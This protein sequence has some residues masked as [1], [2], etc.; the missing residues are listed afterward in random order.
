MAFAEIYRRQVALLI[1]ILPMVTEE[2][3]FA[4][5]GGTAINLFVRDLP[6]LSVDLDLTY[7]PV[8]PRPQS[9]ADINAAMKRIAGRIKV[10]LPGA[11]ITET[12]TENTVVKLTVRSQGVQIKIE[13]TPVLRGCVFEPEMMLVTPTV[14]EEFGFAE[15][16]VVS[17]A[18]LYAGKIVAALDRQHPRD[19]FDVRDLLG[20]EGITDDLRQAFI[21]YLLSH[22]RPMSEVLAPTLINIESAFTRGFSGMTRDPVELADLL[23]A[24]EAL[25]KSIVG[26]MSSDHREF[27]VSFERGKP[28]WDLL[29]LL[30]AADLP[31]VRWRQQNLDKLSP[32]K[33]AI[34]VAR[35]EE[36]LSE[37]P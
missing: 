7:L 23:A 20:N 22:D 25:I 14:Q 32:T 18:D 37:K 30:N 6:R 2:A 16:R 10:A 27:L 24:R 13:V 31:A 26:D 5:K 1:R 19:L 8:A 3:C 21:V 36:V 11:Q 34:L 17:F 35:L 15:A 28:N 33:R 9:L 4:L 29:G 12:T